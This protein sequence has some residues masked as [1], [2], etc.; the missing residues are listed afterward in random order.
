D[1]RFSRTLT[2]LA[3]QPAQGQ[4]SATVRTNFHW[5]LIRLATDTA[6]PHFDGG[7]HVLHC[8]LENFE[9][10]NAGFLLGDLHRAVEN[11]FGYAFLAVE[12][13]PV[14][15]PLDELGAVDWVRQNNSLCGGSF[16]WHIRLLLGGLRSLRA[17]L[18]STLHPV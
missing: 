11:S 6:G 12:H 4:G 8:L 2:C 5:N 10:G 15:E 16:S 7:H 14:D 1:H 18:A 17:V 3:D 9:G 13:H